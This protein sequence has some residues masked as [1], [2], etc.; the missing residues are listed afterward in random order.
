MGK[1]NNFEEIYEGLEEIE[2]EGVK[3]G[4]IKDGRREKR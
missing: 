4:D 1:E 3:D 2:E